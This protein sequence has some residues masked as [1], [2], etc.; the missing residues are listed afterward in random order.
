MFCRL[1]MGIYPSLNLTIEAWKWFF[2][3]FVSGIAHIFLLLV[4]KDFHWQNILYFLYKTDLLIKK[5]TLRLQY[6]ALILKPKFR[7]KIEFQSQYRAL[8]LK[9]DFEIKTPG[10]SWSSIFKL[11]LNFKTEIWL[12]TRLDFGVKIGFDLFHYVCGFAVRD[13][14]IHS[15]QFFAFGTKISLW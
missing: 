12:K 11:W 2:I 5:I 15:C 14:K 10:W 9:L 13:I 1:D 4:Q 7:F 3:L 6:W 8:N